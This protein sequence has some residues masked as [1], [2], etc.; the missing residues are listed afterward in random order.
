MPIGQYFSKT[1]S[2]WQLSAGDEYSIPALNLW[3][4]ADSIPYLVPF[5]FQ[6]SIFS[7]ITHPK[8]L[9]LEQ[10]VRYDYSTYM[11]GACHVSSISNKF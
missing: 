2:I 11:E 4:M 5:Q 8:N 3:D 9:A 1:Q 10:R 7:L 6:E